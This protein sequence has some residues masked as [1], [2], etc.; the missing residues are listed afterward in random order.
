M[1]DFLAKNDRLHFLAS[2][3][4]VFVFSGASLVLVLVGD[5]GQRL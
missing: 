5:Y 3:P 1:S 2:V 4:T